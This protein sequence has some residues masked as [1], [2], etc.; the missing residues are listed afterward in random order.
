MHEDRFAEVNRPEIKKV[1]QVG[2]EFVGQRRVL[3]QEALHNR[4][5]AVNGDFSLFQNFIMGTDRGHLWGHLVLLWWRAKKIF[6]QD[7]PAI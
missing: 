2:D 7:S 5:G 3:L 6:K 4:F 1:D